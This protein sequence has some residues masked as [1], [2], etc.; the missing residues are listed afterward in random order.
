MKTITQTEWL[1]LPKFKVEI[2]C[3]LTH[4]DED[5]QTTLKTLNEGEELA[6]YEILQYCRNEKLH[7]CFIDFWARLKDNPDKISELNDYEARFYA[8]SVRALLGCCWD[9]FP[10]KSEDPAVK[11]FYAA[12][13]RKKRSSPSYSDASLGVFLVRK[14]NKVKK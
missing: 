9:N 11:A 13:L 14:K 2:Q 3:K 1:Y 6:T 7:K 4:L 8:D 10:K 12:Y 5:R